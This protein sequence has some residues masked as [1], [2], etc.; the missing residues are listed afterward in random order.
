MFFAP[1]LLGCCIGRISEGDLPDNFFAHEE[2]EYAFHPDWG[3]LEV[4]F[5]GLQTTVS[6]VKLPRLINL[7]SIFELNHKGPPDSCTTLR[8]GEDLHF[9]ASLGHDAS[10]ALRQASE[11]RGKLDSR[12]L[13]THTFQAKGTLIITDIDG[14]LEA[15]YN[16]SQHFN[17]RFASEGGAS[18]YI[19]P[20]NAPADGPV[21]QNAMDVVEVQIVGKKRWFVWNA[22]AVSVI[23]SGEQH[24]AVRLPTQHMLPRIDANQSDAVIIELTPGDALYIPRGMAHRAETMGLDDTSVHLSVGIEREG[25]TFADIL[26]HCVMVSDVVHLDDRVLM[27]GVEGGLGSTYEGDMHISWKDVLHTVVHAL[28]LTEIGLRRVADL[29]SPEGLTEALHS[30][31][32]QLEGAGVVQTITNALVLLKPVHPQAELIVQTCDILVMLLPVALQAIKDSPSA[33]ITSFCEKTCVKEREG[34]NGWEDWLLRN[35]V[36]GAKESEKAK[37]KQRTVRK[38]YLPCCRLLQDA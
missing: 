4:D 18:L 27:E 26:A 30:V 25:Y 38:P 29:R 6:D 31:L 35:M 16:I 11:P 32:G 19:T 36:R 3:E 22:T 8:F 9:G 24:Q 5:S 21:H 17:E 20:G 15:A 13:F 34:R 12:A 2:A 1:I 7:C 14:R 23:G 37:A 10:L 33:V 28:S